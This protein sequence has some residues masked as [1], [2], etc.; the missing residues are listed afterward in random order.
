MTKCI[1][2]KKPLPTGK[3]CDACKQKDVDGAKKIGEFV[4]MV[5]TI[6][7]VVPKVV[8]QIPS[9]IKMLKG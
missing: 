2:C 1:Q 8:K 9:F 6:V 5:I 7:K 3:L 4:L